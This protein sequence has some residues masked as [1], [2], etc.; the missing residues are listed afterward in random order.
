[1]T[2]SHASHHPGPILPVLR[3]LAAGGRLAAAAASS[4]QQRAD[5]RR[6]A[7]PVVWPL[8]FQHHTRPL[9][10]RRGHSGCLRSIRD[11]GPACHDRFLD[12]V[13]AVV[14]HL[15]AYA[16][17]PISNLE[18]W[19]ST[20]IAPAVVDGH[21]RRRGLRGAQQR[22]R[23]PKWLAAGLG[24]D[25]WLVD[26]ARRILEW[27]G[28]GAECGGERWPTEMWAEARAAV[29]GEWHRAADTRAVARD[30]ESVCTTMRRLRPAW[31]LRYVEQPLDAAQDLVLHLG[32]ELRTAW[33]EPAED[34][35]RLVELADVTLELID[36]RATAGADLAKAVPATLR[37]VFLD[38]Y[39]GAADRPRPIG[40]TGDTTG[41]DE[42][43]AAV[44][45]DPG[46]T[47]V[48]VEIVRA[49]LTERAGEVRRRVA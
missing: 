26:L 29:T 5:L 7:F 17:T 6:E 12:D 35:R 25:P 28:V 16:R 46:R 41:T 40:G 3:E 10:R 23:V 15:L 22:P 19:I 1:M 36:R 39:E 42:I 18:G 47:A 9:E 27:A 43:V 44:L 30:V 48:V 34:D 31:Y 13:L 8:V 2:Q 4:A 45:D 21:R 37:Q 33:D 14:D 11:L 38:R 32:P 20:R 49:I 24:D